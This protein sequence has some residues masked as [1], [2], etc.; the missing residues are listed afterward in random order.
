MWLARPQRLAEAKRHTCPAIGERSSA[1]LSAGAG[2]PIGAV[3]VDAG[4][5]SGAL[6]VSGVGGLGS[7]GCLASACWWGAG[8]RGGRGS[9]ACGAEVGVCDAAGVTGAVSFSA[10]VTGL[11]GAVRGVGS[12]CAAGSTDFGDSSGA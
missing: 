9:V 10:G 4:T 3:V 5:C 12:D 2:W 7:T 8:V 1:G 6:G 11:V